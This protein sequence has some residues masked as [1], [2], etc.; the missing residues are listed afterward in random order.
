MKVLSEKEFF[1]QIAPQWDNRCKPDAG[2]VRFL[3]SKLNIK[4]CDRILDIGTGTGVLIPFIREKSICSRIVGIDYSEGMIN[5]AKQKFSNKR[6]L[7]FQLLDIEKE[8]IEGRF[9]HII[10]YSMFPHLQKKTETIK[11]LIENN[12]FPGGN[13]LIAHTQ[14]RDYL[15]KVHDQKETDMRKA[16]LIE[17]ERQA[18]IFK[19]A[20]LNVVEAFENDQYYY[21]LLQKKKKYSHVLS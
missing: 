7:D 1:N 11:K 14:S 16:H 4:R 6:N 3:L 17:V 19:N 21:L 5:I 2:K 8:E 15:N 9:H 18:Q 12:L 10:L 13:I 20:S